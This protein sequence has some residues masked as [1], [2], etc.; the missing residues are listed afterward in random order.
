MKWTFFNPSVVYV[1][2]I[3][4]LFFNVYGVVAVLLEL[5]VVINNVT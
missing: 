4:Y 1:L 3:S 2:V 5:M